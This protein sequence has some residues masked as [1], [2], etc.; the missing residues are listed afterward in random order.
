MPHKRNPVLSENLSGLARLMR[1]YA[2]AALEDIALWHERDISHSS[3]ERVIAP[4]ATILLD[5]ILHRFTNLA[6]KLVVYPDRML[7]NLNMTKGA[8]FSQMV[9]LK[10][11]E[12]G[13]SR[14][15]AYTVV[16]RN[17]MKSWQENIDFK[18]LLL[19]DNEVMA[20]LNQ[21]DIDAV[22]RIEN[23]LKHTDFIFKRVFG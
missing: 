14:E 8:I 5:F 11:I 9:L 10:L 20:C 6:D 3:V 7:V 2:L 15:N 19:E 1:S 4:D 22:F 23:F 13:M 17:A 21:N 18:Q 16:Q 12:K